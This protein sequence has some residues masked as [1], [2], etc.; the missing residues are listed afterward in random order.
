M[1]T[2]STQER[3]FN[4][5]ITYCAIHI[6]RLEYSYHDRRV[7]VFKNFAIDWVVL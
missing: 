3:H 7:N 4:V 1:H 6:L 2:L 5:C